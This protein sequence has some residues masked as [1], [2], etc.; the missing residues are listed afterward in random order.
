MRSEQAVVRFL[1]DRGVMRY[2]A[3]V[4]GWERF[5]NAPIKEAM[6]D[7]Q[8]TFGSPVETA[9][10]E[11]FHDLIR[12]DYPLKQ[13]RIKWH[14]EIQ[15]AE[16]NVAQA[17][18]QRAHGF[19]FRSADEQR[20]VQ[21]RQDGFTF[22]WLKRYD[23][24]EVFCDEARR[25]WESYRDAFCPEAVTRL[26]LR[27]I[28]RIGIPLPFTDFREYVKTAP[29]VAPGLPQ[30]LSALFMRLE[31]PDQARGLVAII[32]ETFESSD[33]GDTRLPFIF[34]IDV[35]HQAMFDPSNPTIWETFGEMRDYKNEIFFN[36]MTDRAC[37]LFR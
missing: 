8:V 5:P 20:A 3:T 7:I 13:S 31:I 35:V 17:V 27:Y 1:P 33:E 26:G 29:D 37:E 16:G 19:L 6:L 11:T 36:S 23:G 25:H 21:A 9:R 18:K 10:L 15:V 2:D 12:A 14:G 34:D 28:N 4:P 30:S 32:T 22:N 24:W